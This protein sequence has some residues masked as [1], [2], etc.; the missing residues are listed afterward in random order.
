MIYGIL[1]TIGIIAVIAS[2]FFYGLYDITL[3]GDTY[4][5]FMGGLALFL[6]I[7]GTVLSVFSIINVI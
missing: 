7:F 3:G 6:D 4:N 2:R 5:N 1:L